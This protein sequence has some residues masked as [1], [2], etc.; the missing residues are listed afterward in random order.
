MRPI[1]MAAGATLI[2]ACASAPRYEFRPTL[3]AKLEDAPGDVEGHAAA[4]YSIT[5]GEVKVAALGVDKL[6]GHP[7]R[8]AHLRLIA[9]NGSHGVWTIDVQ[10]QTA[11]ITADEEELSLPA[12][13]AGDDTTLAVLMPGD[14]RTLDLYYP[15]PDTADD[16]AIRKIRLEWR[17]SGTSRVFAAHQTPFERHALPAPPPDPKPRA[18]PTQPIP[19]GDGLPRPGSAEPTAWSSW[20]D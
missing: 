4:T 13:I 16:N 6:A 8:A 9:H 20:R 17:I 2:T 12:A 19:D 18:N 15:L 10:Q 3:E 1:V 5:E 7:I 14:T 11:F